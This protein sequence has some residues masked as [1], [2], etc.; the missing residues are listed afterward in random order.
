MNKNKLT[1]MAHK[2]AKENNLSF[3]ATLIYFF[4]EAV[5]KR[6]ASSS[7][8][9]NFI[10]KGGF[11]LSNVIGVSQRTTVDMD[12]ILKN[13]PMNQDAVMELIKET[14]SIDLEDGVICTVQDSEPIRDQDDYG[15]VRVKV[16][17]QLENIKQIVPLDIA[18]GDPVTPYPIKYEYETLFGDEKI[19]LMSYNLETMLAE[20]IHTIYVRGI[21][22]SRSK[23]FYDVYILMK[24]RSKEIDYLKIEAACKRTFKYRN[25]I[26]DKNEIHEVVNS[27]EGNSGMKARWNS[28]AKKNTFAKDIK[29]EDVIDSC[30]DLLNKIK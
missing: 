23:D 21:A 2:I 25:T 29:F 9:E 17:C 12:M 15:G 16:L 8:S 7:A 3:N 28:F 20:K 13:Y 24:L 6:I 10:F 4:L 19:P 18:T 27:I 5:L 1:S 14:V 11:L 30:R 26:F 22:N